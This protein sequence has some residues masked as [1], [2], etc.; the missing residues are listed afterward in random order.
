MEHSTS[1]VNWQ[2]RNPAKPPGQMRRDSLSHI[3]RGAD[4]ALFFQW[5]ASRAGAEKFHSGMLPH[6]GTDTARWREV[7]AL[8]ADLQAIAPTPAA[9]PSPT[10]P[11]PST[12]TPGGVS[13][14]TRTRASTSTSWTEFAAWHR[15]LWERGYTCDFV[16]PDRDLSSY[17][18]VSGTALYLCTDEAAR[19]IAGVAERGGTVVVGYFSGIADVDDHIRMGGYPGAFRES[20]RHP[21]RGVLAAARR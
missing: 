10:S 7:C 14:W 3:A 19:N 1:A 15:A 20:A 6:A 4:G 17:S 8:G 16:H 5:R 12:G 11:S 18:L 2:P 21:D 9:A 13:S